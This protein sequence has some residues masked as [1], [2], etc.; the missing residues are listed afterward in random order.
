MKDI[1]RVLEPNQDGEEAFDIAINNA[2]DE[3]R[4]RA[5]N[6]Y[7]MRYVIFDVNPGQQH[8]YLN[9]INHVSL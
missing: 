9:N 8:Y 2:L 3:F 4:R 6:A 5:D 1:V 7:N